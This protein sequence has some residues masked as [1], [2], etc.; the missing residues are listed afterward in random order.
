VTN[1]GVLS[2]LPSKTYAGTALE[3]VASKP[4]AGRISRL[5]HDGLY[6]DRIEEEGGIRSSLHERTDS[7]S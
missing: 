4:I 3:H 5:D 7:S 2:F 1:K 6:L